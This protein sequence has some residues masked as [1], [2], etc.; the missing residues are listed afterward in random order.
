MLLEECKKDEQ[1][2]IGDRSLRKRL[3]AP[4]T[5]EQKRRLVEVLVGGVRV[6][7]IETGGVKQAEITVTYRFSQPNQ[8]MPVVLS[9]SYSTG[10]IIR[11]P[12][13]PKTVGDHI[14]KQRLER[15]LLQRDV[16]RD[17]GVTAR[18]GEWH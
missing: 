8:P 14:R 18:D 10:S 1:W 13:E 2:I 6:E 7:T 11:I 15:K 4:L 5:W 3:D 9:Q 17:I 16:A 12:A